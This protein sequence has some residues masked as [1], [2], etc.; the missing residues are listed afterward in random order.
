MLF[1]VSYSTW[2]DSVEVGDTITD[3]NDTK[4]KVLSIIKIDSDSGDTFVYVIGVKT[5]ELEG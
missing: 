1:K 4:I 2:K 5:S 3:V